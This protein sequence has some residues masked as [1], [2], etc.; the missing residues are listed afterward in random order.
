MYGDGGKRLAY[1]TLF[2][3]PEKKLVISKLDEAM[4]ELVPLHMWFNKIETYATL[5][6]ALP[7]AIAVV[8]TAPNHQ[9]NEAGPW[10]EIS[11]RK[12]KM[13][14]SGPMN[15]FHRYQWKQK[16]SMDFKT[17]LVNLTA[18]FFLEFLTTALD[19]EAD[20]DYW[21]SRCMRNA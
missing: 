1:L 17:M 13:V 16:Q 7:V 18:C 11:L 8:A 20:V 9:P 5:K 10:Q 15:K 19:A 4:Y 2:K 6:L 21:P 14:N 12:L 3:Q